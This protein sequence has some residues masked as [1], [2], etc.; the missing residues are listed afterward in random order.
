MIARSCR[1]FGVVIAGV[2]LVASFV[3][4]AQ[5]GD[6]RTGSQEQTSAPRRLNSP[7]KSLMHGKLK[8][9]QTVLE[10]LLIRD[11]DQIRRGATSLRDKYLTAPKAGDD[12]DD[13]VYEHFHIEFMRLSQKLITMAEDENLE[14]AAFVH[15]NLTSTCI[16]CHEHMRDRDSRNPVKHARSPNRQS[17][18]R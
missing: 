2:A 14:G 6:D 17:S 4:A 3:I 5:P 12:D 18:A 9:G 8:D 13:K 1:T 11:F 15:Q 10:G 16:A 7:M